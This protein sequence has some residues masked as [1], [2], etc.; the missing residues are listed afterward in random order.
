MCFRGVMKRVA[1]K[2][3][4]LDHKRHRD[5]FGNQFNYSMRPKY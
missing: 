4:A 2:L 1:S 3:D 5:K